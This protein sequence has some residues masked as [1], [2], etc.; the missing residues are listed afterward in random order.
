MNTSPPRNLYDRH[1]Y[2]TSCEG[3]DNNIEQLSPRLKHF[4][5]WVS[6]QISGTILDI[7][8]GRGELSIRAARLPTVLNIISIDYS[9]DAM[10]MFM[11]RLKVEPVHVQNKIIQICGDIDNI[12]QYLNLSISHVVAFDVVEHI[13]P[14]QVTKLFTNLSDKMISD[15]K[16]FVVT[17]LSEAI[18]NERHVW[19]AR[20][21]SDLFKLIPSSF[22]C[23]H[24]GP[25]GSGEDHLFEIKR[26]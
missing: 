20:T 23:T 24:I 10:I 1:Y 22:D 16:V 5:T 8:F 13:Y 2:E 19:L 12:I 3:F 17:P 7:G 4:E 26:K 11:E 21:P 18:P 9:Y 25:S 14:D 15:G 6:T